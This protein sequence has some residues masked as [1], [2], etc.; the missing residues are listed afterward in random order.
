M[1]KKSII[2]IGDRVRIKEIL[3][4]E[5]ETGIVVRKRKWYGHIVR[6]DQPKFYHNPEVGIAAKH[7]E[8]I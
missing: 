8:K 5:G 7:L 4:Y 2:K 1:T 3:T 6:L